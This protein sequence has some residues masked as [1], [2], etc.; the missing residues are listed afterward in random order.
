YRA[1]D[2]RIGRE[3]AVKV[4]PPAFAA[5]ADSVRRFEQEARAAGALNHPGL[6]T[7]FDVGTHDDLLYI[8]SEL[9]D[10]STLRERMGRALS[11]RR[12]V[13]YAL[14]IA[15]G[16]AVAHDKGIVHRDLKPENIFITDDERVKL[17]DFGLA[18][19]LS[20]DRLSP[21]APT[22]ERPDTGAGV[23]I[24]T[25]AYMSPEQVR[26]LGIDHRTDVF[27]LGIVLYEML[28]GARPFRATSSVET[29]ASILHDD[30]PPLGVGTALERIVLHA[31][32]KA[33]SQRFQSMTDVVFALETFSSGGETPVKTRAKRETKAAPADVKFRR[34]SF[35]HGFVMTARFAPDGSIV[36]G[37]SWED[38]PN[39]IFAAQPGNPESRPVGLPNADV[40][41]IAPNG[42]LAVSLGRHYLG[43]WVTSGTLARVPAFGG[44]PRE[45]A[46]DAQ[47][48]DWTPDGSALAVI[49]TDADRFV[50]EMPLGTRIYESTEWISN[51]RV[52]PKGDRVA[53]LE[54][55]KWGDDGGRIVVINASGERLIESSSFHSMAGTAWT[56]NGDEIWVAAQHE[57]TGRD[58]VALSMRGRERVV[59]PTPGLFTL[60]DISRD[61]RVLLAVESGRREMMIGTRNE[62]PERNLTWLDWS[63][64]AG[65]SPDGSRVVFEEQVGARRNNANAVYVRKFDGSPAVRF[66]EGSVRAFS[67]DGRMIGI[68]PPGSDALHLM[69]VGVGTPR[70]VPLR[71][72]HSCVWWDW[73]PDATR[74]VFWAHLGNEA[75]RHYELDIEGNAPP[76][77]V[78]PAGCR[79]WFAISPDSTRVATAMPDQP[80]ALYPFG[81]GDPTPVPGC[82]LGDLPIQWSHDG[83]LFVF[84]PGRLRVGIDR[85][86][87]TTGAR[88][89]WLD[90]HPPDPAGI[91]DIQPIF[92]TRD[93]A[94][95]AYA[96]RR[97]ISDLY[98]VEGLVG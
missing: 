67:P 11:T 55:E 51:V 65:I 58:L 37:A 70:V 31:L 81:G 36:Y 77:P 54:H 22:Q 75:V 20:D 42:E 66:G 41:A 97:F 19:V 93:G 15:R 57:G 82:E 1:R 47:D 92:M 89:R 68:I 16:L 86:D 98:I 17:L 88:S 40:L 34:V 21:D 38:Q 71:G 7:I 62:R 44:A 72:L 9:L 52:S 10:G 45:L 29:M 3:V 30:P 43:G 23:V 49:R 26:G 4:L 95:Y 64:L 13:A 87:L 46:E 91:M 2:P 76:R 8:V 28:C 63:F 84:R 83:A 85:V 6:L 78:T 79:W 69:P 90:L 35:R 53:F 32:Q 14:Q 24:G 80:P 5:H 18:K 73:T 59:L 27:S 74:M 12:A 96:Y 60:Y 94:H 25:V 50:I 48:A 61:G 33:Q 39:E 56:P